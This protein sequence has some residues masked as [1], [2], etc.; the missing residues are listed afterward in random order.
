MKS[1]ILNFKTDDE[2][3]LIKKSIA[4][5]K[6]CFSELIKNIRFIYIKQLLLM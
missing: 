2:T 1:K 3:R 5:D 4:G 6:Q